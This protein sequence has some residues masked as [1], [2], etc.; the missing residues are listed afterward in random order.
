M[1]RVQPGGSAAVAIDRVSREWRQGDV[2]LDADGFFHIADGDAAL[3]EEAAQAVGERI[4]QQPVE[5]VVVLSQTCDLVRSC[6][7]RPFV[8]LAPLQE[9]VEETAHGVERG[10]YPRYALVPALRDRRLVA[11]LDRVMTAEKSFLTKWTRT[12]G[13]RTDQ[14]ARSFGQAIGRKR[15]RF[16]FPDDFVGL[17]RKLQQRI[18]GKHDKDSDDGRA[19]RALREIRVSA[20]PQREPGNVELFF[21]FVRNYDEPRL[22]VKWADMLDGWLKLVSKGGR[23]VEVGG[24]VSTLE[25]M[26]ARDYVDSDP[27]DFDHLTIADDNAAGAL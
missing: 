26:S 8:E 4:V 19:L 24:V 14:E 20:S 21:Y 22:A 7:E 9:V 6:L 2:A 11:D 5:G 13:C 12:R 3:T 1:P 18:Q 23:F 10:R 27:L 16:A 25:D 15:T 17:V